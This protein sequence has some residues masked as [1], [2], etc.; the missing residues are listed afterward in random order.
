LASNVLVKTIFSVLAVLALA[1]KLSAA[2][3]N[4]VANDFPGFEK[5]S[6]Y[7]ATNYYEQTVVVTGKV[8]QVTIRPTVTFINLDKAFPDSPFAV[9]IF[10][11]RSGFHGN[12]NALKGRDIGIKGKIINY[13]GKPE[14]SLNEMDQLT[15]VGVTNLDVFLKPKPRKK[16][17]H[18]TPSE[19]NA[20]VEALTN[21]LPEI[22]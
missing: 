11:S 8:V 22:M 21:S 14:I 1:L 18:N 6:S 2:E 4:S 20:P 19:T 9:V 7:V 3:T 10:H 17:G 15:V 13:K 12:V 5:I 16:T